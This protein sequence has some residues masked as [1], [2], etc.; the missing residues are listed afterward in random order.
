MPYTLQ[1]TPLHVDVEPFLKDGKHF[2]PLRE[3]VEALGGSVGFDNDT[4]TAL[5]TI[6]P[7]TAHVGMETTQ[8]KVTGN[9]KVFNVSLTDEPF[10]EDGVTYVPFDLLRDAY[11]YQVAFND[12]TVAIVNPNA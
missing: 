4:K 3:V 6:G 8:I 12:G 1:G 10:I 7:W 2:I 5:A 9:D 11:G